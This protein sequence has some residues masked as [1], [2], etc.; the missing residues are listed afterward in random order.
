[1]IQKKKAEIEA[2]LAGGGKQ[3][4]EAVNVKEKRNSLQDCSTP[5]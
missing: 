5:M 2:K 3:N 1:M 4:T